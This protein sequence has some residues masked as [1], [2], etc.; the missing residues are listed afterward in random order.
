M[1][2]TQL[3]DKEHVPIWAV[4]AFVLALVALVCA[5]VAIHRISIIAAT[6]Q[7]EVL[8]LNKKLAT[9]GGGAP[10]AAAVAK[11]AAK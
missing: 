3:V 7:A 8:V 2:A 11:S 10:A 1:T 6:T 9:Q 4:S 5:L